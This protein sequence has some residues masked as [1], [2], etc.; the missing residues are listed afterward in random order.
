MGV[1]LARMP[2]MVLLP[3]AVGQNL[4]E[5]PAAY[6]ANWTAKITRDKKLGYLWLARLVL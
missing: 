3:N 1:W 6:L 4:A 5:T 2:G